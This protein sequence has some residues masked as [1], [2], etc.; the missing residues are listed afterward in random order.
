[1]TESRNNAVLAID[2]GGTRCR[3]AC[4]ID[5]VVHSVETGAANVST[6]FDGALAQIRSGLDQVS[7]RIGVLGAKMLGFPAYVGLAGVT[8]K[9]IAQRLRDA[10]GLTCA[11]VEDDRPAAVRGA[12]GAQDGLIA[13]CGTGSFL[14]IQIHGAMRF[15]GGWGAV[16]GD[17]ASAQWVGRR[18][19]AETLCA[20]DGTRLET[21]LTRKLLGELRGTAGI[22]RF[23][24]TA[25][26]AQFGAIAPAVTC[27]A[28]TGDTAA[29]EIM[30]AGAD[31]LERT[32]RRLGWQTCQ[33]I[34]L[35]GGIAGHYADYLPDDM[36]SAI[37]PPLGEPLTGAL[38]LANEVRHEHL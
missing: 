22:V 31:Y 33:A 21:G 17:E 5:G 28:Q 38:A 26:P 14:A 11:R 7:D 12:L 8:D 35:T 30:Q 6:D 32:A 20:V 13:H 19:L 34:C 27:A 9:Q 3:V 10:L 25:T 2:G 16:L 15:A 37:R 24:G 1:M 23:A 36:R 18:A 29:V 4:M